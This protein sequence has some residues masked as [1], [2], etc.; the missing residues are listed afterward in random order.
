MTRQV[1]RFYVSS[2]VLIFST[3]NSSKHSV[4]H[5]LSAVFTLPIY[6]VK[7]L[8]KNPLTDFSVFSPELGAVRLYQRLSTVHVLHL[9]SHSG[10]KCMTSHKNDP[11][12]KF[13]C[14]THT[15]IC[16]E[17]GEKARGTLSKYPVIN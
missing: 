11:G 1:G 10:R 2:V 4:N 5:I 8:K 13:K 17:R 7:T 15:E 12:R 14:Q 16:L 9:N 3:L 6:D